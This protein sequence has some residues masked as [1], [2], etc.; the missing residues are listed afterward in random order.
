M[1]KIPE[2]YFKIE[3]KTNG[4]GETTHTLYT[5]SYNIYVYNTSYPTW[6]EREWYYIA[7]NNSKQELV[8]TAQLLYDREQDCKKRSTIVST[9]V[10]YIS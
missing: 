1:S 2:K 7:E 9:E 6:L 10:E 3:S 8:K 5:T 4:A